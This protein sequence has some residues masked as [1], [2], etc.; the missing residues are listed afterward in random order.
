[1]AFYSRCFKRLPKRLNHHPH[2]LLFRSIDSIPFLFENACSPA[3][4]EA[5]IPD[6]LTQPEPYRM[7]LL[8][9]VGVTIFLCRVF[10]VL[11]D[12]RIVAVRSGLKGLSDCQGDD[13]CENLHG[14][15]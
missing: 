7:E 1:M 3:L 13:Q 6:F 15:S 14:A 10:L 12:G 11:D 9:V 8:P 5:A 4:A 2:P